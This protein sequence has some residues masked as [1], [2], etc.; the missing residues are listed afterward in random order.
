M[1]HQLTLLILPVK[2]A[3]KDA[4][5]VASHG[6]VGGAKAIDHGAHAVTHIAKDG[7]TAVKEVASIISSVGIESKEFLTAEHNLTK[8]EHDVSIHFVK[9]LTIIDTTISC[10]NVKENFNAHIKIGVDANVNT[11]MSFGVVIAGKI[12]PPKV[13]QVLPV[14]ALS[15]PYTD[16]FCLLHSF[17]H[18]PVRFIS[19]NMYLDLLAKRDQIDM[20]GTAEF[21]IHLGL[22]AVGSWDSLFVSLF[23]IGLPG[24]QIPGIGLIGPSMN[25]GF[26]IQMDVNMV[27]Q[28]DI[29]AAVRMDGIHMS[30]PPGSGDNSAK[31]AP[32]KQTNC[33]FLIG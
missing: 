5:S 2:G 26:R 6:V 28:I 9:N 33:E 10:H 21:A 32:K 23:K 3:A 14:P 12:I 19:A 8:G 24:L 20:E 27:S 1:R 30:F 22:E 31:A 13:E 16:S 15:P 7:V 17:M 18:F 4:V 29:N 25:V 11:T